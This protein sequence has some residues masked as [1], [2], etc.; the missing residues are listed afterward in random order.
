MEY[1]LEAQ[2]ILSN[3]LTKIFGWLIG[4]DPIPDAIDSYESALNVYVTEKNITKVVEIKKKLLEL[5]IRD[6]KYNSDY[7]IMKLL[8]DLGDYYLSINDVQNT[9]KYYERAVER[10]KKDYYNITKTYEH[11]ANSYYD[12]QKYTYSMKYYSELLLHKKDSKSTL[13][14]DTRIKMIITN[15]YLR[16]YEDAATLLIEIMPYNPSFNVVT[17]IN[18]QY[19]ILAVLCLMLQNSIIARHKLLV[20][21]N[22]DKIDSAKNIVI[23]ENII[24][25][26]ENNDYDD[27][28]KN[29]NKLFI[30]KEI[31][32]VIVNVIANSNKV[33]A[34]DKVTLGDLL[35]KNK[36]KN[37]KNTYDKSTE[38]N[39]IDARSNIGTQNIICTQNNNNMSNTSH[40]SCATNVC[41][42]NDFAM[43]DAMIKAYVDKSGNLD[44]C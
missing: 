6:T 3:K 12:S 5:R 28:I 17:N 26:F 14:I 30:R 34:S 39:T 29:I 2:K 36:Y 4:I 40:S 24:D 23:V 27:C 37:A 1:E 25:Y 11:I 19:F 16:K 44:L 33:N 13:H 31:K 32:D 38:I 42:T 7:E 15:I 8:L 43:G 41:Q 21:I 20:Y 18:E 10:S 9:E 22:T 35:L